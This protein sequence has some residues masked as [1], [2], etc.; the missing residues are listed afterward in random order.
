LTTLDR[1]RSRFETQRGAVL[2]P[3]CDL[4]PP[5][6]PARIGA[7]EAGWFSSGIVLIRDAGATIWPQP[8]GGLPWPPALWPLSLTGLLS[9]DG[10]TLF[11]RVA[12]K[13]DVELAYYVLDTATGT[14]LYVFP[15]PRR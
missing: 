2:L 10:R 11:V 8:V 12:D 14:H 5:V 13:K 7:F 9:D 3:R 15:V 1:V 4:E 6:R